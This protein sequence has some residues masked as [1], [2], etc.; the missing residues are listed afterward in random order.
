VALFFTL[1]APSAFHAYHSGGGINAAWKEEGKPRVQAAQQ[2]L[3]KM[4]ARARAKLHR[5]SVLFYGFRVAEPHHDATPHWHMVLFVPPSGGDTLQRVLRLVWLSEFGDEAGAHVHRC[6]AVVI[7]PERGSATGYV[8][9]YVSK[10]IDGA[11]A[12]G[13]ETSDET[14][15][16]V[17]DGVARVAAWAS[18]HGIRQFQQVGGPP[19]GLWREARRL[20]EPVPECDDIERARAAADAGDWAGFV[21]AVGVNGIH[22]GRRCV[23]Q[24]DREGSTPPAMFK[25]PA[26]ARVN[27]YAESARAGVIGLADMWGAVITRSHRWRIERKARSSSAATHTRATKAGQDGMSSGACSGPSSES[28]RASASRSD[29]GPV[30][31]TVRGAGGIAAGDPASWI[32]RETSTAGPQ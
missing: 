1:T 3:R 16:P 2:W 32:C 18:C 7:D 15:A 4:W 19:V 10:N 13:D 23:V 5:L 29:L 20:R 21:A 31:I 14:G 22:S 24:L 17:R 28:A 6:K 26:P 25:L 12:I 8:A 27:R 30:A 11:G 9:K